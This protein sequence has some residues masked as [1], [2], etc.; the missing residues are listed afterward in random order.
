MRLGELFF[1]SSEFLI[2]TG[3]TFLIA[4]SLH[5]SYYLVI[6]PSVALWLNSF[7]FLMKLGAECLIKF[8]LKFAYLVPGFGTIVQCIRNWPCKWPHWFDLWHQ[9]W[10]PQYIKS[11]LWTESGVSPDICKVSPSPDPKKK[12]QIPFPHRWNLN[13][14][15]LGLELILEG[16]L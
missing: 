5:F 6:I 16:N 7:S 9:I 2:F 1:V 14:S 15:L 11:N 8:S 13:Y 3:I 10:F 4:V 12:N